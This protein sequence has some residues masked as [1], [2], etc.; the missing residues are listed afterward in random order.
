MK[1]FNNL[2]N[3]GENQN[4]IKRYILHFEVNNTIIL[5]DTLK[6]LTKDE[7]VQSIN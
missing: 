1:Q 4:I 3:S 6:Q 5:P 2:K 7:N